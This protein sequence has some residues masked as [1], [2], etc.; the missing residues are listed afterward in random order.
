MTT[1]LVTVAL[2]GCSDDSGDQAPEPDMPITV[3]RFPYAGSDVA[4]EGVEHGWLLRLSNPDDQA[5]TVTLVLEGVEDAIFGPISRT[6]GDSPQTVLLPVHQENGRQIAPPSLRLEPGASGLFLVRVNEYSN[7]TG[8][9]AGL[10]LLAAPAG[11]SH[12]LRLGEP[13]TWPVQVVPAAA[14][15]GPGDHVRTATVGVWLNGTSFYT[16]IPDLLSDPDFPAGFPRDAYGTDPLSIYVYDQDRTEQPA[17]SQDACIGTTIPGY[18]ALLKQQAD[19]STG[20]RLL[21]PEDAYTRDGN[22]DHFLYGDALVFL[23]TIV[24]HDG[25][26]GPLDEL[27]D[28]TGPCFANRLDD[29]PFP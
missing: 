27:P 23:N 14:V 3:Y 20:V 2:A 29:L 7:G 12:E 9:Q 10:R 4:V 15:V 24:A 11:A 21:R 16:N 18:N 8:I 26:T 6:A 28:P 13:I 25:P 19:G 5:W 17:G 1:L 22:Q